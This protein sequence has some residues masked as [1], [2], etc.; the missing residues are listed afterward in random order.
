MAEQRP[1]DFLATGGDGGAD[2]EK[3]TSHVTINFNEFDRDDDYTE[4]P[5]EPT[6]P[7]GQTLS[8]PSQEYPPEKSPQF[9]QTPRTPR[10][11]RDLRRFTSRL[12]TRGLPE[13]PPPPDGGFQA[14]TQVACVS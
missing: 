5:T 3:Q 10:T 13:P 8:V 9:P 6:T 2:I 11:P 12:S 7:R 14:W 1:H 4:N